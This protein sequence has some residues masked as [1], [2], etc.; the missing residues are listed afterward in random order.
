ME[1]EKTTID[2]A[3]TII[4]FTITPYSFL[5]RYSTDNLCHHFMYLCISAQCMYRVAQELLDT[6]N[7]TSQ[8]FF[9]ILRSTTNGCSGRDGGV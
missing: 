4:I 2:A 5:G 9:F 7:D 8:R 1:S 6:D 3:S